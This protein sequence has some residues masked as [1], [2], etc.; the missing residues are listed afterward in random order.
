[1]NLVQVQRLNNHKRRH[2][3]VAPFLGKLGWVDHARLD[4]VAAVAASTLP[5]SPGPTLVVG[6]AEASLILAWQLSTH[7]LPM[8][9]LCFTTREKGRHYQAYPFQEPH[10]HGP[11]HWVAVAP[12]RTYDRIVIIEDEVTTGTTITNLSLVLRDHANRFDILTLMDMR[13]KE[14]RATMEQIYAAHGLTMTFSALSHLPSPPAFFP[15]R[16]DGRRCLALDQTPNPHQRPPDAYAQVFRTLSHLWQRQRVGA[17][18]M[19]GE[20]V[21]VP[22]AFCSSLCLEHRPPIQHVTLS[23]WV[24]DG[25]GVRTRV[26]FI[27]HRNGVAGDPYYLY[28]WNHPAST[29][30]VIVSDTST[31]AVAEQVRLFLQEHEVEVTVLEV[32]L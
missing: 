32:P 2:A 18:Y 16:C 1:M 4:T 25:L 17:L 13:S 19:I 30:A 22:M 14:H 23:P 12:G 27:N 9:D 7:L 8:P 31:C 20:C 28:N 24:V 5:P 10:S 26:D 11:A 21:D 15:P 29:Q 6:L 3:H